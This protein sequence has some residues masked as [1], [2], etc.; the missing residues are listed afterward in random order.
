MMLRPT[1]TGLPSCSAILMSGRNRSAVDPAH[2]V[3]L[4]LEGQRRR[5]DDMCLDPQQL[6][7]VLREESTAILATQLVRAIDDE[8]E[9][10]CDAGVTRARLSLADEGVESGGELRVG[11]RVT[12]RSVSL[13]V[14]FVLN[15]AVNFTK[16]FVRSGIP[17]LPS[18]PA[19]T[20][21]ENSSSA[22]SVL[23]FSADQP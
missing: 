5:V 20:F 2:E 16:R 4:V 10:P 19:S 7:V 15:A 17:A 11:V 14:T 23:T 8:Q 18:K 22:S 3:T 13:Y 6:F 1:S 12:R 21:A 9:A